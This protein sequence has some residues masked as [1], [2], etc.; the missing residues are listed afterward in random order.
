MATSI[1][2][3]QNPLNNLALLIFFL[4]LLLIGDHHHSMDINPP[5]DHDSSVASLSQ[6]KMSLHRKTAGRITSSNRRV[7]EV[8]AHEVPSGPNP[9]SN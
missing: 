8:G 7:F 9:I 4:I 6:K 2:N 1:S 5:P 3:P